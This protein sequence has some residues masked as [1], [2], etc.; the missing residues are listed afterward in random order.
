MVFVCGS[1][2]RFWFFFFRD[3]TSAEVTSTDEMWAKCGGVSH[4]AMGVGVLRGSGKNPH[5]WKPH[6]SRPRAGHGGPK[7]NIDSRDWLHVDTAT[8]K[9]PLIVLLF[10]FHLTCHTW[11][12]ILLCSI[13]EDVW[14][15]VC[16]PLHP[17]LT[18]WLSFPRLQSRNIYQTMKY[19]MIHESLSFYTF[20]LNFIFELQG[21]S[22]CR[23]RWRS[24]CIFLF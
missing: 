5:K 2:I 21:N 14:I 8:T 15:N 7:W 24:V 17:L 19:I 6:C 11:N 3:V 16:A 1:G 20:F 9:C 10:Q 22:I 23:Y 13:V 18:S 12:W 4:F